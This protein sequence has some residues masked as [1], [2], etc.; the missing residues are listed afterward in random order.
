M[1]AGIKTALS[2]LG[3]LIVAAALAVLWFT[4][5]FD[6]VEAQLYARGVEQSVGAQIREIRAGL[7]QINQQRQQTLQGLAAIPAFQNAYR[8]NQSR[9]DIAARDREAGLLQAGIDGLRSLRVVGPDPFDDSESPG[10]ALY[11][12]SAATDA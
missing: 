7:E 3:G 4:G 12:S 10:L 9:A 2:L 5:S 1:S 6:G 8:V 11:Y